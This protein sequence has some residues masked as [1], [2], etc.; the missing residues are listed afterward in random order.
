MELGAMSTPRETPP[1]RPTPMPPPYYDNPQIIAVRQQ[2][3]PLLLTTYDIPVGSERARQ[4][5]VLLG[6][7]EFGVGRECAGQVPMQPRIGYKGGLWDN[8]YSPPLI[9]APRVPFKDIP[10]DVL[11][12]ILSFEAIPIVLVYTRYNVSKQWRRCLQ[13]PLT[14]Y[15]D[16]LRI[17][18]RTIKRQKASEAPIV[19][20]QKLSVPCPFNV[21]IAVLRCMLCDKNSFVEQ[22][23]GSSGSLWGY[24]TH[25]Q[26]SGQFSNFRVCVYLR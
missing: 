23:S 2:M 22:E 21:S 24:C 11:S 18:D 12:H 1:T 26:S 7:G 10:D 19:A 17:C 8:S 9:P 4:L 5:A 14:R 20:N 25:C 16:F 13:V 6:L 3:F 15:Y